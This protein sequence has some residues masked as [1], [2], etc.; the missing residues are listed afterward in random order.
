MFKLL[1]SAL[2][3][4]MTA[5][6][7][8]FRMLVVRGQRLF[9]INIITS[10]LVR[11]LTKKVREF[12]TL[13]PQSRKDYMVI[14]RWWVY[15]KLFLTALLAL[16]AGGVLLLLAP[17]P[18]WAAMAGFALL[19]LGCAPIFPA[20][21]HETPN[22]FGREASQSLMGFQMAA[23]YTG[24]AIIS[25][26]FGLLAAR[27]G[28]GVLPICLLLVVAGLIFCTERVNRMVHGNIVS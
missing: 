1:T 26:C 6:S 12:V 27:T 10:K 4:V 15:K 3:R 7:N 13:R 8:P 22:R 21:L 2:R 17:L 23:A 5:V 14:G 16:C 11:P 25:P 28:A 24:N 20:M 18:V 19:G 9:N